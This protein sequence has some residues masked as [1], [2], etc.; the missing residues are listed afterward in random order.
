MPIPFADLWR[1]EISILFNY[2][3]V[4]RDISETIDLYKEEKLNFKDMVTH[5]FPL[6]K[7]TEGFKLVENANKSIKVVVVP[8]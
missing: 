2:G 4:T 1:N 7:I 8:D 5:S 3:A 6:S